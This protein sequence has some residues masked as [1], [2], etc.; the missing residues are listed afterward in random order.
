MCFLFT[1]PLLNHQA[2]CFLKEDKDKNNPVI[3]P[4]PIIH[5][6]FNQKPSK[7]AKY[8]EIVK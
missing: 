1:G 6:H 8:L 7:F 3:P 5:R 4:L 2:P